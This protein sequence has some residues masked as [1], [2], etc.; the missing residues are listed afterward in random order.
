MADL[1]DSCVCLRGPNLRGE[2]GG[3]K[4]KQRKSGEVQEVHRLAV[5]TTLQR[6]VGTTQR[7]KCLSL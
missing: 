7:S 1:F 2:K 4:I 6:F 5:R 3:K